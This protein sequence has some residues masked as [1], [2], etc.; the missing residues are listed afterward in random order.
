MDECIYCHKWSPETYLVAEGAAVC[1]NCYL[2]HHRNSSHSARQAE[3]LPIAPSLSARGTDLSFCA[4]HHAPASAFDSATFQPLCAQCL[5]RNATKSLTAP[6]ACV[7]MTKLLRTHHD[8]ALKLLFKYERETENIL[9]RKADACEHLLKVTSM[10]KEAISLFYSEQLTY[11]NDMC[12]H[13]LREVRETAERLKGVV[14]QCEELAVGLQKKRVEVMGRAVRLLEEEVPV[15]L[16]TFNILTQDNAQ[17]LIGFI[18]EVFIAELSKVDIPLSSNVLFH[19]SPLEPVVIAFDLATEIYSQIPAINLEHWPTAAK[20]VMV[21]EGVMMV[22][23]GRVDGQVVGTVYAFL[24]AEQRVKQWADLQ[25]IREEFALVTAGASVYALS[26]R[27]NERYDIRE[28]EWTDIAGIDTDV[29]PWAV[30]WVDKVY[31]T[32]KASPRLFIYTPKTNGWISM[33]LALK[34]LVPIY[35]SFLNSESILVL[36]HKCRSVL[37]LSGEQST[38]RETALSID[39]L[40]DTPL[41]YQGCL[42]LMSVDRD[43]L[44]AVSA[45]SLKTMKVKKF[46]LDLE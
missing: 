9:E 13:A 43:G 18:P 15:S 23:G 24:F 28:K 44:C 25:H 40:A 30:K 26:G 39:I 6:A 41:L 17:Q 3:E 38:K 36:S 12:D 22:A 16:A 45:L 2:K 34:D 14:L 11:I 46:A 21:S 10:I 32:S 7:K 19:L 1:A 31:C 42:C 27:V 35:A 37:T 5:S 20:H 29:G 8:K 33:E 4:T